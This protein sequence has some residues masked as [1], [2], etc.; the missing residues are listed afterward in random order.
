M[1]NWKREDKKAK[2]NNMYLIHLRPLVSKS[3]ARIHLFV[4]LVS[5]VTGLSTTNV[6]LTWTRRR[7][8]SSSQ[9]ALDYFSQLD[10]HSV[11]QLYKIYKIDFE[12][13]E[14]SVQPYFDLFEP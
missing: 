7:S 4:I 10:K 6:T 14:Y 11:K 8:N 9:I 1:G 5:D 12:M 13:F 2:K 3:V